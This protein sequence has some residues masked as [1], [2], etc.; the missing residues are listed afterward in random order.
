M[1]CQHPSCGVPICR[2]LAPT[3]WKHGDTA[4][5]CLST[6]QIGYSWIMQPSTLPPAYISFLNRHGGA[7]VYQ[8]QALRVRFLHGGL[9]QDLLRRSV[10]TG[11]P[12][13]LPTRNCAGAAAPAPCTGRRVHYIRILERHAERRSV[14]TEGVI[15]CLE[16]LETHDR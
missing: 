4:L 7:P 14:D 8:V 9:L 10:C 13:S 5:M 1:S 12:S 16:T 6:S 2:L 3:R 15:P 11:A